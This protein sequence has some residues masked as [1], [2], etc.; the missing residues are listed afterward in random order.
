[1][2]ARIP[3][4]QHAWTERAELDDA[5]RQEA[6]ALSADRP[7]RI[8]PIALRC[9][10]CQALKVLF[11]HRGRRSTVFCLRGRWSR[12]MGGCVGVR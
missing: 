2:A 7:E 3:G 8:Q 6:A 11:E 4:S 9:K 5:Q 12:R 1:M 10:R